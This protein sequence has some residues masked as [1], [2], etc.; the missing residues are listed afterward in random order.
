MRNG[1]LMGGMRGPLP[2]LQTDGYPRSPLDAPLQKRPITPGICDTF[3][4]TPPRS[5]PQV[6]PPAPRGHELVSARVLP[7]AGG[8]GV[9]PVLGRD[10][11][12]IGE[13]D[14]LVRHDHLPLLVCAAWALSTIRS[15]ARAAA[16]LTSAARPGAPRGR[17]PGRPGGT[18]GYQNCPNGSP[19][20]CDGP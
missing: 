6:G 1:V 16:G 18:V 3:Q 8:L 11:S 13:S 14:L 4:A 12:P 15:S 7:G 17:C 9:L 19:E 2:W 5:A 20:H 10:T